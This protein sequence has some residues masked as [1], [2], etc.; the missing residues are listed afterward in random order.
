LSKK[1]STFEH[2]F[3]HKKVAVILILGK[4]VTQHTSQEN[5]SEIFWIFCEKMIVF[6]CRKNYRLDL[7]RCMLEILKLK[8]ND[9][10]AIFDQ[11]KGVSFLTKKVSFFVTKNDTFFHKYFDIKLL[12]LEY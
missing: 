8:K 12:N 9:F 2:F 1:I 10:P 5:E 3:E 7:L 6:R 11:K 4:S